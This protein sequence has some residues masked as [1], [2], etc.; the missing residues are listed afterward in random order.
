MT[1]LE[2]HCVRQD[3]QGVVIEGVSISSVVLRRNR[4]FRR[5]AACA[6]LAVMAVNFAT[7]ASPVTAL[8]IENP[9]RSIQFSAHLLAPADG[10]SHPINLPGTY[11][12]TPYTWAGAP[13]AAVS[14]TAQHVFAPHPGHP[15]YE[16]TLGPVHTYN[17]SVTPAPWGPRALAS[18]RLLHGVKHPDVFVEVLAANLNTAVF[19][20]ICVHDPPPGNCPGFQA[21]PSG[22]EAVPPTPSDALA[23]SAVS[24]Y[25]PD[26]TLSLGIVAT[27]LARAD[28]ISSGIHV[29][30]VG[31]VGPM[32]IDLGSGTEWLDLDGIAIARVLED[33]LLLPQSID[34]LLHDELYINVCTAAYPG[35]EV[36]GQIRMLPWEEDFDYRMPLSPMHGQGEWKGWG[37]DPALTAYVTDVLSR[38]A[39]HALEVAGGADMVREFEGYTSGQ[40]EFTTWTY[41]PAD[42][43][44]GGDP[45][46][47]GSFFV[48]MNRYSDEG[49][50]EEQ[51]WSVQM[52]FDSN[53]GM[54]KVYYGNGLNTVNVPY[55]TR[56]SGSKSASRSISTCDSCAVLLLRRVR[57]WS[58][59]GPAAQPES[60]VGRSAI[61]AVDLVAN[62]SSPI[63]YDD[64][65]LSGISEEAETNRG[66][67]NCDGLV[68]FG[69]IDPFVLAITDA[70]AYS[71]EY[72]D[73]DLNHADINGDG[74]VNFGDIDPFV[75]LLTGP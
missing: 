52:Q 56:R 16:P 41:V 62:G 30:A 50:W 31:E 54:L 32:I 47:A 8:K 75:T 15:C 19:A 33:E 11:W 72:P 1:T 65:T 51:D 48:M 45:P 2:P 17:L 44:S 25:S 63:W 34:A 24:L 9:M 10:V 58:T 59:V 69:D 26:G 28:V 40:W 27:G 43:Q 46:F 73:C 71:L 14:G 53:D 12:V 4:G 57:S 55:V 67:L 7:F 18:A 64:F 66:D 36:R 42:F 38:S 68:N 22:E 49:P 70:S 60:A 3:R 61:A 23:A 5:Q 6:T 13:A 29:G 21:A 74:L 35:G 39:P 37:N 20:E